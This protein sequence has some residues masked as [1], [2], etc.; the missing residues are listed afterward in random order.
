[1]AYPEDTIRVN[2]GPASHIPEKQ[3]IHYM[4]EDNDLEGEADALSHFEWINKFAPEQFVLIQTG[5]NDNPPCGYEHNECFEYDAHY[6]L[7]MVPVSVWNDCR[8][9]VLK[10]D[11]EVRAEQS[12]C[13]HVLVPANQ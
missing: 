12:R 2:N 10:L 7:Y 1:M 13:K 11:D 5:Y 3:E 9:E 4:Y 8:Q 6:H